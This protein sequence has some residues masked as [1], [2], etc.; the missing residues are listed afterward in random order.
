MTRQRSHH[1]KYVKLFDWLRRQH[2]TSVTVSFSKV[3]EILGLPLPA[4]S[5]RYLPHWYG[6]EGS[7]VARSIADA[8]W[9]AA[10]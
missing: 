7:A 8:G 2:G 4:S 5:R 9:R 6:Y 1:G 10:A 3:E